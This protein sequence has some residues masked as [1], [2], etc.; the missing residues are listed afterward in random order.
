MNIPIAKPY[1]DNNEKEAV[2]DSLDKGWVVQGPKVRAFEE[3]VRS[4]TRAKYAKA[5]TSCTTALH[6]SLLACGIKKGDEVIVPSFTFI[7]T[8]N[9]VEYTGAKPVFA[10]INL[11]TYSIDPGSL[12][13]AVTP[14]TKA[15]MPVHLFGLCADMDPILKT[16][17]SKGLKIVEDAACG[18]GGFYKGKHAGV[19]G[20]AGCLSFHPRK[21]ITTGEG[22][23]VIT[24]SEDIDR[25]VSL[26]RDHGASVS[27]L[28]RHLK[29]GYLLPDYNIVGYNYRMTDIQ[30]GIGC[31]QMKKLDKIIERKK[32]LVSRYEKKLASAEWLKRPVVPEGCAHGYQSYVCLFAPEKPRTLRNVQA[33]NEKRNRVMDI[34]ESRGVATR[35]GTHAVHLLGYYAKKYGLKPGD[36]FNS[37]AADRLT[38]ALPLYFQMTEEE[39]DFVI[40]Q[41]GEAY[42]ECAE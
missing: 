15:L 20:D 25:K 24:D 21:S 31:E 42:K 16:A 36:F 10:D 27:D 34:L 12:E 30:G 22:G 29:K 13:K 2:A 32:F 40:E 1:F 7:A 35:Q 6:A 4:Y 11:D 14:R 19:I 26:L 23:M 8:A 18:M 37:F 38:L 5:V 3:A 39:Q 17:R 41:L 33:M 9:A 28:Q